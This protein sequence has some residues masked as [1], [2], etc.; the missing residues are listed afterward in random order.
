M[1]NIVTQVI[2]NVTKNTSVLNLD[3]FWTQVFS[4]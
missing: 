3:L 1:L 2:F 4:L